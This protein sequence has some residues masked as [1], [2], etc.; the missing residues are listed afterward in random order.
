MS[1][2]GELPGARRVTD[3]SPDTLAVLTICYEPNV[4]KMS[5]QNVSLTI[6]Y[7]QN[8]SRECQPVTCLK[9]ETRHPIIYAKNELQKPVQRIAE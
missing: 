5:E 7:E 2:Q 4:I 3:L 8:V 6:C 1:A 9:R